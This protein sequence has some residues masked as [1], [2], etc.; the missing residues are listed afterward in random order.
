[1]SVIDPKSSD[2]AVKAAGRS[3]KY[4]TTCKVLIH[5]HEPEIIR[6]DGNPGIY[7]ISQDVFSLTL[8]KNIKGVGQALIS[9]V[10]NIN[11]LNH[12]GPNDYINVYLNIN[13]GNGWIRTFFGMIDR[14]E[15]SYVV[16]EDGIPQTQ[17]VLYCTDFQK[18][19]EVTQVYFN[20]H[21]LSRQDFG[22]EQFGVT[23]VGGISLLT[24]GIRSWGNPASIVKSILTLLFGFGTQFALPDTYKTTVASE[25]I[26]KRYLNRRREFVVK[27]LGNLSLDSINDFESLKQLSLDLKRQAEGIADQLATATDSEFR[28]LLI[29]EGNLTPGDLQRFGGILKDPSKR[30]QTSNI[31]YNSLLK[32]QFGFKQ[33]KYRESDVSLVGVFDAIQSNTL[34]LLDVINIFD[35]I[36]EDAIDGFIVDAVIWSST[37]SVGT[38]LRNWSNDIVNELFFDLRPMSPFINSPFDDF[39]TEEN[40][41]SVSRGDPTQLGNADIV[42]F[43]SYSREPDEIRGNIDE[44]GIDG[45][46]IQFMPTVVMREYPFGT[47]PEI[48]PTEIQTMPDNVN[49]TEQEL[50]L[51]SKT[52]VGAIFSDGPNVRGRHEILVNTINVARLATGQSTKARK[53]LD[54]A[55]IN[56][57]DI[58][59]TKFS[60]SDRDHFNLFE[61][62]S[63]Q[64]ETQGVK[65]IMRELTPIITPI[66]VMRH[67]LRLRSLASKFAA[68]PL[69]YAAAIDRAVAGENSTSG[70]STESAIEENLA[71]E[72]EA[73]GIATQFFDLQQVSIGDVVPP[74]DINPDPSN[75]IGR[76]TSGYGYRRRGTEFIFHHG[77]DIKGDVGTPV[78]AIMN[79]VVVGSTP[80]GVLSNYGETIII[81]HVSPE[82]ERVFTQYSHLSKRLVG[83]NNTSPYRRDGF[84]ADLM[85][86]GQFKPVSVSRGQ[87]IGSVGTT[88]LPKPSF[89]PPR[90]HLHFEILTG[91]GG[92]VYPASKG[93]GNEKVPPNIPVEDPPQATPIGTTPNSLD[94]RVKFADWGSSLSLSGAI[95]SDLVISDQEDD[96]DD[97]R[98]FV[99]SV[100]DQSVLD[101]KAANKKVS[102]SPSRTD[103]TNHRR[104]LLR[105][106]LLQDHWY[107]HNLEYLSGTIQMRG[108]PEIRVGYRLD[109]LDRE[110][111]FYVEG[112]NHTWTFP[113]QLITTLNVSRG[114]PNNPYP[115]YVMPGTPIFVGDTNVENQ[116]KLGGRLSKFAIIPDPPAV[117]RSI[118][119]RTAGG[120]QI[121]E[122]RSTGGIVGTNSNITDILD[123]DDVPNFS[124]KAEFDSENYQEYIIRPSVI[125]SRDFDTS[126]EFDKFIG[127][128][129]AGLDQVTGLDRQG[130]INEDVKQFESSKIPRKFFND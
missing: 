12:L 26:I 100:Q 23:N 32:D 66:H 119:F 125:G 84:S 67:G 29:N 19:F 33:K 83:Q 123:N 42:D 57:H 90:A 15:E 5:S 52:Q 88:Q 14:I 22:G 61:V 117:N 80:N 31:I 25:T 95:S 116:R 73:P 13:D 48:D 93:V 126:I 101:Q 20:P 59:H 4:R 39:S 76:I 127:D 85:A 106:T 50:S 87:V 115:I 96:T 3:R 74:V 53:I 122:K 91:A 34:G 105:W 97:D 111:S 108:A 118:V 46:G 71:R 109:I 114:Q 78:R 10:A 60:K 82:G 43:S 27:S 65:N 7:D 30:S 103:S 17:Y 63:Q 28:S 16:Q 86:G 49:L 24:K 9:A 11:Y 47:I 113:N 121:A 102:S 54:V 2:T 18:A 75:P 79:G 112:V 99:R 69:D 107:Q 72:T 41:A 120:Y 8:T 35:F 62:E 92:V 45:N 64:L 94:P 70:V 77:V 6:G 40:N 56:S 44:L 1:M 124:G 38:I 128:T 129:I 81:M 98:L 110:M 55:V 104:Q 21:L 37:G 68:F 36:E 130:P 51:I 89:S 58:T